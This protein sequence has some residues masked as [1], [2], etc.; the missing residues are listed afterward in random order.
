MVP[1]VGKQRQ[2]D[3]LSSTS[4]WSTEGLAAQ[5]GL[6]ESLPGKTKRKCVCVRERGR[7]RE[8]ETETERE[9]GRQKEREG[10]RL[11]LHSSNLELTL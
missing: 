3:L 8:R 11:T 6:H 5:P 10:E 7:K 1:A 2:V 4:A 9:K